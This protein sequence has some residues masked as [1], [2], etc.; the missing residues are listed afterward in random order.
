MTSLDVLIKNGKVIDGN[1]NPW[2]NADIG[3]EGE[4]IARIGSLG[5]ATADRVIDAKGMVVAPGFIDIHNHSDTSLL[6]SGKAESMIRQG[7]TTVMTCSCGNSP[8]P[9]L[10][11]ALRE[12]RTRYANRYGLTVDW[13]TTEEYEARLLRQG[14]SINTVLQIGHGT[15]RASV[16]GYEAR[17]PTARE[18]EQMKS[19]V[20]DAMEAGCFGMSTGLGYSP[21]M[22]AETSEVIELCKVVARYG[23]IYST[24]TRR[25]FPRNIEEAF[26][27]GEKA[28]LPVEMSH[29]GSSTGSQSNWGRAKTATLNLVDAARSRGIDFTADLYPYIASSTGLSSLLPQW[30]HEGGVPKLLERI[31][32]TDVRQKLKQELGSRDWSQTY[33]VSFP[34]K[35]NKVYEGKTLQQINGTRASDPV[36]TI[37]DLL[38]EEQ[39]QIS[40]I[41]FF[42]LEE[43]IRTL[44]KHEVVMIGSDGS[45]LEPMG[46]LGEG[47]NHPRN[48]GTFV[49]VL[50]IYVREGLLSLP[51]AVHK[52]SGMPA[53][54]LKLADRGV[55]KPGAYADITIFDPW[56]VKEKGTWADPYQFPEG[57]PY[58]LVNGA[59]TI[60]QGEHTGAKAG[61]VIHRP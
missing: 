4:K 46:V 6:V 23:G 15:L 34:S 58:V 31:A 28:G 52:M 16:M 47:K 35:K 51:E 56:L 33:L 45:A 39:G 37:C 53:W 50:S 11:E 27:I 36:D 44:M 2:Y 48:Y 5:N 24:H 17:A 3:I 42:G 13:S 49:R 41:A 22:F 61:E 10:G 43:D 38:L 26:E 1:G 21:G 40:Y 8:F 19:L 12:T 9:L 55:L 18:M 60:D 7:V 32:Q 30:V 14:I 20:A 54:R 57:I 29:I 25:G 59:V